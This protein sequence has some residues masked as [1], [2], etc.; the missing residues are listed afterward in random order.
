MMKTKQV[1]HQTYSSWIEGKN[2]KK[3]ADRVITA[4]FIEGKRQSNYIL[5]RSSWQ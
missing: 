2:L 4:K 5:R 1:Y 3:I